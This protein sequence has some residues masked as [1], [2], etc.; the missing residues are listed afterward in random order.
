[1]LRNLDLQRRY[2]SGEDRLVDDFYSPCLKQASLYLR[3][4]GFY[5]SAALSAA[6]DGLSSFIDSGGTMKLVASPQLS[7]FDLDSIVAGY[8]QRSAGVTQ[9]L[10]AELG[11]EYPDPVAERLGL[12]G[13]LISKGRLDIKLAAVRR[14]DGTAGIYHEKIGV[15][16]D[17]A[18]DAVAFLGSANESK[19]GLR[20][21]F[22]SVMVFRSW[23]ESDL[24]DVETIRSDFLALW[25]D[26]TPDLE[27]FAF[28][29]A[30]EKALIRLSPSRPPVTSKA[31][32]TEAL[33]TATVASDTPMLPASLELRSY[34]R[35]A[36]LAWLRN[37]ARGVLEMAT[38]TGKTY[39]AL[40]GATRL[41]EHLAR[42]GRP[43]LCIIVCPY[44]HLVR[45]W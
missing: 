22:E 31:T 18:G 2:R 23:V 17:E 25:E 36:L 37:D 13:W 45:Q 16:E 6:A 33:A 42:S 12:L 21:N 41:Q 10:T 34:Q 43:L 28:P 32:Q 4:V 35:E 29:E 20:S 14:A 7:K 19:G 27:V 15:F 1:M 8:E 44:Q 11:V 40:A 39:T 24:A 5:S 9:T 26:R 30:A 3:A 38:G